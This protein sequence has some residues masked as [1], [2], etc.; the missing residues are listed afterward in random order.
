VAISAKEPLSFA[1]FNINDGT[2][3][4]SSLADADS[5]PDAEVEMADRMSTFPFYVSQ[6]LQARMLTLRVSFQSQTEQAK[7]LLRDT[8]FQTLTT[9]ET[10]EQ[11]LIIRE[12]SGI[13]KYVYATVVSATR[14]PSGADIV[15]NVAD[16]IWRNYHLS[17]LGWSITAT[18]QTQA[19]TND[20]NHPTQPVIDVTPTGRSITPHYPYIRPVRVYNRMPKHLGV[21]YPV[22]LTGGGWDT[23][24]EIGASKMQADGDD[25]RV[26]VN[27][28]EVDRWLD[29]I[30]DTDTKVWVNLEM[31][32]VNPQGGWT[33]VNAIT[34]Q[35]T[36]VV[37]EHTAANAPPHPGRLSAAIL[38]I[39]D[40]EMVMANVTLEPEV[41]PGGVRRY[42]WDVETRGV[43]ATSAASHAAD[44][45]C[46]IITNYIWI[47]YGR[48]DVGAPDVDDSYKPM[49]DLGT[50]ENNSWDYNNFS[51]LLGGRGDVLVL[52]SRSASWMP[53][54]RITDPN[55]NLRYPYNV[56]GGSISLGDSGVAGV[57]VRTPYYLTGYYEGGRSSWASAWQIENPCLITGV[58]HSG[59]TCQ[60][61]NYG[62]WTLEAITVFGHRT[63]KRQITD[64]TW[65]H[66]GAMT[67]YGPHVDT[68]GSGVYAINKVLFYMSHEATLA[69]I[70]RSYY[71]EVTD[72]TLTLTSN[73][74]YLSL[75]AE[76][77]TIYYLD[78]TITNNT[79]EES[80]SL[81]VLVDLAQTVR[82]DCEQHT[83][84]Y[85]KDNQNLYAGFGTD[86]I[87]TDWLNLDPGSN[88]LQM[89][90]ENLGTMEVT[91][92]YRDR[93]I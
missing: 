65:D 11:Q 62:K 73:V 23:T 42:T 80:I 12:A 54:G 88:E 63:I 26:F 27:N 39:D 67:S 41:F 90:D 45:T 71:G 2:N 9:A 60:N 93:W 40:E 16:P 47:A 43:H 1:G 32:A 53:V 36:Q 92:K 56:S 15:L 13:R 83:V 8:L 87:R 78:C 21:R 31:P 28:K 37:I 5:L 64:N 82:I 3:Y 29:S 17:E 4:K 86:T 10:T 14:F 81:E 55:A 70:A 69:N 76:L 30:N 91:V 46:W 49:F 66:T 84:F 85:L 22:D 44:A 18:G 25:L 33:L 35:S 77:D 38:L 19:F 51:D 50:S 58:T 75:G 48:S 89:D 68:F 57:G 7:E 34:A 74:P 52:E 6:R 61:P 24:V 72:V 20:G 79:T 59:K